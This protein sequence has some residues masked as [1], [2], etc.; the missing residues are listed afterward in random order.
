MPAARQSP[1]NHAFV[2]RIDAVQRQ[3][4]SGSIAETYLREARGYRGPLPPTLGFLPTRGEYPPAM[5]AA[6]GLPDEP[7][8]G[9]FTLPERKIRGVHLTRLAPD[10]RDRDRGEK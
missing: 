7:E 9:R 5:I 1:G 3:P 4:L 2:P 6:F 8:P 10:G